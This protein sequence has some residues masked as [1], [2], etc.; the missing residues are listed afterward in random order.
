[1]RTELGWVVAT[2]KGGWAPPRD[3][4]CYPTRAAALKA[5]LLGKASVAHKGRA[6]PMARP[7][8]GA[9]FWLGLMV[10]ERVDDTAFLVQVLDPMRIRVGVIAVPAAANPSRN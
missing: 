10:S 3:S 6:I 7:P 8:S 4:E 1:M 2:S 9:I 5:V